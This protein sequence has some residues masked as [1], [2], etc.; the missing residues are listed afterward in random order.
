MPLAL[1]PGATG[2]KFAAMQDAGTDVVYEINGDLR[3]ISGNTDAYQSLAQGALSSTPTALVG[4]SAGTDILIDSMKITNT[5]ALTRVVT[6]YKTR[7]STTYNATTQWGSPITLL[8]GESAGWDSQGWNTYTAQG[9]LKIVQS[10]VGMVIPNASVAAQTGFAADTYLNGSNLLLPTGLIRVGT[11][12]RWRF[13]VVKTAAGTAAP[14]VIIRFGT[15]GAIGDTARVTFTF[16]A[17]TAAVDRGIIEI[18]ANFRTVGSGTSAV[19][20]GIAA[21]KHQ[22]AT[23]GL[24]TT[25]TGYQ[26]L[27]VT[28]GGFD[29]TVAN[30][31]IGLSVNG[32]ASAAWTVTVVQAN[33]LM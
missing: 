7:N 8:A 24:N 14:T 27:A 23:T 15:G 1:G 33:A 32:G 16:A 19:I 4:P 21:L 11:Q 2:D 22:L 28:S 26:T 25:T 29:S 17:Q 20:A 10:S 30:S 9:I 5:G 6:F 12:I 3:T 18:L 13:D 31:Y